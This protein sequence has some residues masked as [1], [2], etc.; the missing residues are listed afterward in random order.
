LYASFEM[1]LSDDEYVMEEL[2]DLPYY[3]GYINSSKVIL[4][5]ILVLILILT[6]ILIVIIILIL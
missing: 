1:G 4:I 5:A 6:L 2:N 3:H